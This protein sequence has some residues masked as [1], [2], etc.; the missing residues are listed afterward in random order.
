MSIY[1]YHLSKS[2]IVSLEPLANV[3]A[4]VL[5]MLKLVA[6]HLPTYWHSRD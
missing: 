6:S 4:Y 1:R 2:R 5:I 3:L